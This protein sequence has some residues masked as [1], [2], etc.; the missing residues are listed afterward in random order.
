[1]VSPFRPIPPGFYAVIV[2]FVIIGLFRIPIGETLTSDNTRLPLV[3]PR[4]G[5]PA[6]RDEVNQPQHHERGVVAVPRAVQHGGGQLRRGR[7]ADLPTLS[8][9]RSH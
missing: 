9:A 5:R 2:G 4:R 1:M 7:R 6:P 3:S 8:L